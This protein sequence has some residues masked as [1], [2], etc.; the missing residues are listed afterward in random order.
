MSGQEKQ[1]VSE[2]SNHLLPALTVAGI[3][4][5]WGSLLLYAPIYLGIVGWVR[6]IF[7]VLGGLAIAISLVGA[8]VEL[9]RLWKKK[10]MGY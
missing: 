1:K 8:I 5:L 2:K 7:D 6:I 4:W 9:A 3:L 10:V